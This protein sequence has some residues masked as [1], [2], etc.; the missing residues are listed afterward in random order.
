MTAAAA[1]LY[2]LGFAAM[3]NTPGVGALL[4]WWDAKLHNLCLQD[5]REGVF[6]DQKWMDY[7]PL[8]LPA[9]MVLRHLGFNAA[10]WNLHERIPQLTG[11][12]WQILDR[13]GTRHDLV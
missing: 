6:T 12:G 9:S 11:R 10:Y 13:H 7:A 1:G 3:R 5:V 2:N 8:L 4:E